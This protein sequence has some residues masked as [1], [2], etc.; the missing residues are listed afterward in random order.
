MKGVMKIRRPEYFVRALLGEEG[1][2]LSDVY[3]YFLKSK[4]Y[5]LNSL[6]NVLPPL[7]TSDFVFKST[8]EVLKV[9]QDIDMLFFD[10]EDGALKMMS[11]RKDENE[12]VFNDAAFSHL[13]A[14]CK[15]GQGKAP[16]DFGEG[17]LKVSFIG[18]K[19]PYFHF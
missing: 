3:F 7:G 6:N 17:Y 12:K 8:L 19:I 2:K 11:D 10:C 9:D 14:R 16:R 15:N 18:K 4:M 1:S 13:R 5:K